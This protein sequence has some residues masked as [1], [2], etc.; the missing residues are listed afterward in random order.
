MS[1][2]GCAF[3]TSHIFLG[4]V[5]ALHLGHGSV[6]ASHLGHGSVLVSAHLAYWSALA[7]NQEEAYWSALA[8]N[9]AY[10][11]LSVSA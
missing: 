6:S 2:S 3:P 8:L 1:G 10:P 7:L 9:Q 11:S 5:S 4:T